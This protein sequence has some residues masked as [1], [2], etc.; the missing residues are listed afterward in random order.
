MVYAYNGVLLSNEKEHTAN[1]VTTENKS[2]K[3]AQWKSWD[4]KAYRL[5]DFTFI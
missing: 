4:T 2:Q 1:D 5:H 3:H